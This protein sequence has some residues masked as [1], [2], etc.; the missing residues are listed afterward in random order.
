MEGGR[1]RRAE[2][3]GLVD[4]GRAALWWARGMK[5][6]I[7]AGRRG[8]G[9]RAEEEKRTCNPVGSE[10]GES[11]RPF[12]TARRQCSHALRISISTMQMQV[13]VVTAGQE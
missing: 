13:P 4:M 1:A 8:S 11:E 6:I 9:R 10:K 5:S 12:V 2:S 3:L 7:L